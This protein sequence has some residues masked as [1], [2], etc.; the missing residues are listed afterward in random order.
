MSELKTTPDSYDN[1][2]S[3]ALFDVTPETAKYWESTKRQKLSVPLCESCEAP[4]FY[5][6][7]RCPRC[8]EIVAR[9]IELTGR[10][11]LYS[12]GVDH[13]RKSPVGDGPLVIALIDLVEGVRMM[14]N[15][16]E[17]IGRAED[18]EI[19]TPVCVRW[20]EQGGWK[21]PMFSPTHEEVRL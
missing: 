4:F 15:L 8:G 6:R 20:V 12:F 13:S 1:D 17:W 11:F 16:V 10:G 19:G 21:L 7:S 18:I 9:W 5:P 3:Q 14:S 2:S